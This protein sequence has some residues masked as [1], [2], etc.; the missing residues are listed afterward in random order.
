MAL[1]DDKMNWGSAI[2]SDV[3]T[4]LHDH[5]HSDGTCEKAWTTDTTVIVDSNAG[6]DMYAGELTIEILDAQFEVW[7]KQ[8]LIK[9]IQE[10]YGHTQSYET[11]SYVSEYRCGEVACNPSEKRRM[12]QWY[13]SS[14]ANIQ[15]RDG[16]AL[17]GFIRLKVSVHR[18]G[19]GAGSGICAQLIGVGAA[20]AG[21][22]APVLGPA[23][24]LASLMCLAL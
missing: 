24:S 4:Q 6:G 12:D 13:G 5:C 11:H 17:R 2:P 7:S 22:V 14:S 21:A 18:K 20:V 10:S 15:F 3:I 1:S 23:M 9:V 16:D 8:G 19:I